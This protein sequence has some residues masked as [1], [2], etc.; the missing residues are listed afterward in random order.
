MAVSHIKRPATFALA[1]ILVSFLLL[2]PLLGV[3]G[4]HD[5]TCS[6]NRC[7]LCLASG[8]ISVLREMAFLTVTSAAVIT[9]SLLILSISQNHLTATN[10]PVLLKT[11]ITS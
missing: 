1:L 4:K 9:A 6:A 3:Y 8:A 5:H 2:S 7:A 10:S 11:K